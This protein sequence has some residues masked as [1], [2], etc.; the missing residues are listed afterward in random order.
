MVISTSGISFTSYVV[1]RHHLGKQGGG[2]SPS[3]NPSQ[4]HRGDTTRPPPTRWDPVIAGVGENW[5]KL[6][7]HARQVGCKTGQC[8]GPRSAA[9]QHVT[10]TVTMGTREPTPGCT[11]KRSENLCSH[12]NLH[13]HVHRR[14]IHS[15]RAAEATQGPVHGETNKNVGSICAL[16]YSLAAKRGEALTLTTVWTGW[17]LNTGCSVREDRRKRQT[18]L[19]SVWSHRCEMPRTGTSTENG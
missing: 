7:P 8:R 1:S 11:P 6:E 12:K 17:A 10:H 19:H 15:C 5:E 18:P 9:P 16:E 14:T 3:F 13:V 4:N 2:N